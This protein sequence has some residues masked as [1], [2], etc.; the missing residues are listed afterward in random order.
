MANKQCPNCNHFTFS[1]GVGAIPLG[2]TLIIGSFILPFL[3]EGGAEYHG[4]HTNVGVSFIILILSGIIVLLK[5]IFLPSKRITFTCSN[6][7]YEEVY[8]KN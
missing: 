4:G 8:D 5:G 6:C 2:I 7:K 1:E 3:I